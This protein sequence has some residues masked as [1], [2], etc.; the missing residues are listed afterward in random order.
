M[1]HGNLPLT[2]DSSEGS[3]LSMNEVRVL[4]DE[5]Q[6]NVPASSKQVLPFEWR[7]IIV[8]CTLLGVSGGIRY[9]RDWQFYSLLRKSEVP[10]FALGEIPN[11]LGNWHAIEGSENTL[12]PEIARIAGASDHLIRTY[13]DEKSGQ[14]T[15]VMILYG[16]AYIVWA[17]SPDVCY[18][19]SGFESVSPSRD[20]DIDIQLPDKST[21]ARFRLQHFRKSRAG[22]TDYRV[23]YYSFQNAGQW[24][25]DMANNWKAFRYH[26][27]MFKV[28]VQCQAS[29]S[30]KIDKSS[31]QELLA[32]I[33]QEI[34]Q[35]TAPGG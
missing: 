15:V 3:I 29:T 23:V 22:Q 17:H 34:E 26:P 1:S 21:F 27:G 33:V 9:W 12:E 28:Q 7:W 31:V 10:P 30:E 14:S 24:G 20:Q 2:D 18:P 5:L 19:A 8:V 16:L 35:R 11:V 25:L 13:V 4:T 6:A 32:R